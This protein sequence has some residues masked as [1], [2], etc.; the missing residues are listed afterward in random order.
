MISKRHLHPNR[1]R[2]TVYETISRLRHDLNGTPR[3]EPAA[4]AARPLTPAEE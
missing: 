2:L 3:A 4:A 1:L